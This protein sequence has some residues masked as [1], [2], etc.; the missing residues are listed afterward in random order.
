MEL[1]FKKKKIE[2]V[3]SK[4]ASSPKNDFDKYSKYGKYN[5]LNASQTDKSNNDLIEYDD[6]KAKKDTEKVKVSKEKEE[7]VE[8]F[9][10]D[11]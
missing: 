8:I 3:T 5:S 10:H 1:N 11:E 4:E 7:K 9:D 6:S 2:E